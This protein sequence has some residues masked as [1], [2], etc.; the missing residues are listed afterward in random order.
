[1]ADNKRERDEPHVPDIR[2]LKKNVIQNN[3][4]NNPEYWRFVI[5]LA[6]FKQILGIS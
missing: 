4:Y 3:H 6:Y 1:M 5:R 2:V